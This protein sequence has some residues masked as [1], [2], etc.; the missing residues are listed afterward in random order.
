MHAGQACKPNLGSRQR[1]ACNVHPLIVACQAYAMGIRDDV[2]LTVAL[3]HDVCEDCHV[4][5]KDLPLSTEVQEAVA[6]LTCSGN[7]LAENIHENRTYI[8]LM[9]EGFKDQRLQLSYATCLLKYQM[10]HTVETRK[11]LK[12]RITRE[13]KNS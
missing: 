3:L 10:V 8:L 1:T 7:D 5:P 13:K 6:F 11:G 12:L 2:T 9:L 4:R